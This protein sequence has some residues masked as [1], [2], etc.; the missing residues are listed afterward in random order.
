MIRCRYLL[1][2]LLCLCLVSCAP[3][4]FFGAGTAMG[5]GGYKWYKGALTVV[6]QAPYME[7][8]DAALRAA[9]TMNLE[10]TSQKHDLTAGKIEA[11]RADK[12]HVMISLKY[13]SAKETEVGIRVGMFGDRSA[14]E[15]IKEEIRKELFKE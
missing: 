11:K 14:S 6:Y 7:A 2:V 15:A 8:W 5:I 3:I 10:V 12:K 1:S 4:L 9:R 13:V